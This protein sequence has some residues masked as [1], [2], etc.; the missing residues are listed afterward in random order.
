MIASEYLDGRIPSEA[1][2]STRYTP[3]TGKV[4]LTIGPLA[5]SQSPSASRSQAKIDASVEVDVNVTVWPV[6]GEAGE[7]VKEACGI[8]A[9]G[10]ARARDATKTAATARR[11]TPQI[12]PARSSP[13]R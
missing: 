5:S 4:V 8:A 10:P 3:A 12:V 11:L 6:S 2:S 7:V 13:C 9:A 1:H